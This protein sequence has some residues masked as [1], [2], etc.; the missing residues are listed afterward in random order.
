VRVGSS[1]AIA[2]QVGSRG[3]RLAIQPAVPP[4][5]RWLMEQCWAPE[6]SRPSTHEIAESLLALRTSLGHGVAIEDVPSLCVGQQGAALERQEEAVPPESATAS[7][8]A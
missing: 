1:W 2:Y 3:K 4:I 8:N 7:T 5:W 6:A